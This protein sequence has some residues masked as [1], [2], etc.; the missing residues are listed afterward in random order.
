MLPLL[1]IDHTAAQTPC[2]RAAQRLPVM[3]GGSPEGYPFSRRCSKLRALSQHDGTLL[4][5]LGSLRTVPLYAEKQ[6][7]QTAA[8]G[9]PGWRIRIVRVIIALHSQGV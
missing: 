7:F 6:S 8:R 4:E 5:L 3:G 9:R 1:L 2:A